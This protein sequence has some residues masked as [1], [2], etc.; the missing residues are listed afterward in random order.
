MISI[1]DKTA[2][3]VLIAVLILMP[4]V[5][6]AGGLGVAPL[7]FVLGIIGLGLHFQKS[8]RKLRQSGVFLTL[9]V[10]L[11]WLCI[12]A[13]WSPYHPDDVLTNYIKLLIIGLT[14]YFCPLTFKHVAKTKF[15][16]LQRIF[17][18]ATYLSAILIFLDIATGF[19]I[20][21]FFNPVSTPTELIYRNN[22]TEM[23][24]GHGLAVLVLFS[25]PIIMLLKQQSKHWRVL[26]VFFG[27]LIITASYLNDL[28]I[29]IIGM[30]AV[31][32]VM[33]LAS[34][35]P[36]IMPKTMIILAA[37]AVILAPLFAFLSLQMLES[38]LTLL[39]LSWEHRIR[40]WAYCWPVIAENTMIGAGFDAVRTFDEQWIARDGRAITVVSLHPHNAGVH[41]WTETGL[42]GCILA[43][44]VI[45]S[46][47][48]TVS[49]FCQTEDMSILISGIMVAIILIS[50]LTYGAWQFW[51]WGSVFF[52]FG[53]IH[54]FWQTEPLI[55]K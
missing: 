14:F 24:L 34:R 15:Q 9:T 7:V 35:F 36:R 31:V 25:A 26:A 49:Q 40:M 53:L 51:W 8:E 28:W 45:A 54:V 17:L 1:L 38:D 2:T 48:K 13:L 16:T 55:T 18:I 27:A 33:F 6:Q 3:F 37:L 19:K 32:L 44:S 23:N 10:F 30:L 46:S 4:I 11:I 50:S 43:T 21:L 22:D 39:P 12:T 42:I 29:G 52:S 47:W 20:T 41:I 5:S